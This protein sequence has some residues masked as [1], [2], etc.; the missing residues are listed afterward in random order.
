ML[1]ELDYNLNVVYE[2]VL[3][4]YVDK[5]ML[6][7]WGIVGYIIMKNGDVFFMLYKG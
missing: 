5:D 2:F 1:V 7:Y 6:L 4:E 3:F